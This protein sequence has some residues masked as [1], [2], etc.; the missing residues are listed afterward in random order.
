MQ[1][2]RELG[3]PKIHNGLPTLTVL[4]VDDELAVRKSIGF[5]LGLEGYQVVTF[6]NGSALLSYGALPEARCFIVD[7]KLPGLDGL[8][9]IQELRARRVSAPAILITSNPTAAIRERAKRQGVRIV[10]KPLLG[11]ELSDSVRDACAA[12]L[13]P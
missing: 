12:A 6:P 5:S 4:V 7:Y 3:M 10:E 1:A 9:L 2:S 8:A 13:D 11:N